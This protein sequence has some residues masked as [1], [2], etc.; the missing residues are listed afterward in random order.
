M[1]PF[2]PTQHVWQNCHVGG[3]GS[4]DGAVWYFHS[5][6]LKR[7]GREEYLQKKLKYIMF[8]NGS[9]L[10]PIQFLLS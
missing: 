5:F 2:Y 6:D 4:K 10:I 9:L 1:S 8:L 7:G 3:L